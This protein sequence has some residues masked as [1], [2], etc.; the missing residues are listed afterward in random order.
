[1]K[2]K[3]IQNQWRQTVE[4]DTNYLLFFAF[5]FSSVFFRRSGF[6]W[7]K[8]KKS[9]ACI[10]PYFSVFCNCIEFRVIH[11]QS[12]ALCLF[13][14]KFIFA[15]ATLAIDWWSK[16]AH[17]HR[18]MFA[19]HVNKSNKINSEFDW[20]LVRFFCCATAQKSIRK[21]SETKSNWIQQKLYAEC[22]FKRA[23]L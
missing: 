20:C 23:N 18:T 7:T 10:S 17:V 16:R 21:Y 15:A 3:N 11:D 6:Y 4:A 14:F 12:I 5:F 2:K 13:K 9:C 19:I 1:M 8:E 22:R